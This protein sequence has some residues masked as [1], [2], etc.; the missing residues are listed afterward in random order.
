M[1]YSVFGLVDFIVTP[2]VDVL[3]IGWKIALKSLLK[4]SHRGLLWGRAYRGINIGLF[5]FAISRDI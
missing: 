3:P 2:Y 1:K 4:E 5:Y